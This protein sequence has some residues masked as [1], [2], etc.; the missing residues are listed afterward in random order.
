MRSYIR[1]KN[2]EIRRAE[3]SKIEGGRSR[4]VK[5]NTREYKEEEREQEKKGGKAF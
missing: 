2:R 4:K 5:E 1:K 3:R